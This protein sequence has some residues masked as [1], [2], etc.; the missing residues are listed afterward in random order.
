M[1]RQQNRREFLKATAVAGTGFWVA[2]SSRGDEK[3]KSALERIR[4]ACIG[5]GGKGDS[6]SRDAARHGD[7]VAIC[8]VDE[9][10]LE[11]AARLY[12]KAK[13]FFDYRKMFDEMGK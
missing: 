6:D 4:F 8:D 11:R 9:Q 13:K 12:P 7:I 10:T 5:V 2:G 3:E 1:S